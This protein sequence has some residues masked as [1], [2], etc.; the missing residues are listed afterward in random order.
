MAISI[1]VQRKDVASNVIRAFVSMVTDEI[2]DNPGLVFSRPAVFNRLCQALDI[3]PYEWDVLSNIL[4]GTTTAGFRKTYTLFTALSRKG[5]TD[6]D[7]LVD[8]TI[9]VITGGSGS[10]VL[11]PGPP[12]ATGPAGTSSADL[13]FMD[14]GSDVSSRPRMNFIGSQVQVA[15]DPGNNRVNVTISRELPIPIGV[16]GA[17]PVDDGTSTIV[18]RRLQNADIDPDFAIASF[19]VSSPTTGTYERGQ[20]V[21]V[22]GSGP[23]AT[24]SY[25]SGPPDAAN[26]SNIYGGSTNV[27]D[28]PLDTWSLPSPYTSG[29]TSGSVK[30]I[31]ADHGADPS[32]TI[33]L[34]AFKG[35]FTRTSDRTLLWT[36]RVYWGN[37]STGGGET[38]NAAFVTG[39]SGSQVRSSRAGTVTLSPSNQYVYFSTPADYGTPTF[40]LNG[41]PFAASKVQANLAVTNSFGVTRQY[42]VWRSDQLLTGSGLNILVS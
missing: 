4:T 26:I 24:A 30:K 21:T 23:H 29:T 19:S 27:G 32:L 8:G 2:L 36:S 7:P 39:L 40:T 28:V 42:D 34:T 41:F 6:V 15:D 9:T 38:V 11:V 13:I 31:G 16:G 14:E 20:T 5:A 37:G 1:E 18:W 3:R 33:R 25:T 35:S 17:V 22:A 10:A 12:G